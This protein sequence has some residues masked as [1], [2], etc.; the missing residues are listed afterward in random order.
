MIAICQLTSSA[1]PCFGRRLWT[2]RDPAAP[3]WLYGDITIC[4][5]RRSLRGIQYDGF[6]RTQRLHNPE[7]LAGVGACLAAMFLSAYSRWDDG[8][9]RVS[10]PA[11]INSLKSLDCVR[12]EVL[13]VDRVW[14][15]DQSLQEAFVGRP[16]ELG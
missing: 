6:S 7:A 12:V 10:S 14:P 3:K 1:L 15:R 2:S 4:I 16:G 13:P 9:S 11:M 8:G 5:V